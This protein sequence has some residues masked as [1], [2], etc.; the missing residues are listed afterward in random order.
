MSR[1][2][3]LLLR[4]F[5]LQSGSRLHVSYDRSIDDRASD[6][7]KVS[8]SLGVAVLRFIR[9]LFWRD[10]SYLPVLPQYLVL[11]LGIA[12]QPF[13][14]AFHETKRWSFAGWADWALFAAI[15]GMMVFPAVYRKVFDRTQPLFVQMCAIFTLGVGW[16]T[17]IGTAGRA[18]GL[19]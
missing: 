15:I 19:K 5:D 4:Y 9:N 8:D 13:L 18:A 7:G 6:G 17:L 12:V 16:Q 2:I 11:T 10:S 1:S 3:R 14:A